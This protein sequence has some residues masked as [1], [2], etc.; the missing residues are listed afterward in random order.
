MTPEK[1][2]SYFLFFDLK[3]NQTPNLLLDEL[4][5]PCLWVPITGT[6]RNSAG[7]FN[8]LCK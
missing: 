3:F 2:N 5:M 6:Q 1:K 7:A 4:K 8:G